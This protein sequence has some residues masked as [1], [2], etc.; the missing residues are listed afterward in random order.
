ML[1]MDIDVACLDEK[2]AAVNAIGQICLHA[3]VTCQRKMKEIADALEHLQFYFHENV[4]FHVCLSY[5][6]IGIG[7]MKLN[8]ALNKDD[9]FDWVKGS[10][11]NC[12]LPA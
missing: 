2:S 9:K 3:P 8:G 7:L 10:P 4:K 11:L 5:M 1:G 12:P 6:Q